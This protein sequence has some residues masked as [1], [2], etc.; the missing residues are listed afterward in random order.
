MVVQSIINCFKSW[1]LPSSAVFLQD[2]IM[3]EIDG[4]THPNGFLIK[5]EKTI[6][7]DGRS[8]LKLASFPLDYHCQK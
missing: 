1:I 3:I 5:L 4:G 7:K 2:T 6:F 8:S